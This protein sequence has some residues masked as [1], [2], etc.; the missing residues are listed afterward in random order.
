MA[1]SLNQAV[2][3]IRIGVSSCLLGE[4][5]RWDGGHKRDAF[6][7]DTLS[8]HFEL[9]PICPEVAI[10]LGSPREPIRLVMT[11]GG[12]RA[13]GVN[14]PALDV[15]AKLASY[16]REMA[17]GMSGLSGYVFKSGSP[18]CGMQRVKLHR[19]RG[20][21]PDHTAVGIYAGEIQNAFPL[22]PVEEE[23]RLGLP[24]LRDCFIECVFAYRRWCALL[25][26]GLT[27]RRLA[28]FHGRHRLALLAHA[29]E[30]TRELGRIV[31]EADRRGPANL[32]SEY[33]PLFM[34][35]LRR[36]ATRRG[37]GNAMRQ[38]LGC[39]KRMLDADGREEMRES[40]EQYRRGRLPLVVP[41]TLLRHHLRRH[42]DPN[43]AGQTY[44]EPQATELLFRT[45]S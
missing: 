44:L 12:P 11:A 10:G 23:G 34:Q 13:V 39:L 35:V 18:S 20:G 2:E 36:P 24:E 19:E 31:A 32:A 6:V 30:P 5:V 7:A 33:G 3:R 8:R 22:L 40:I 14:S 43:L 17:P 38:V 9:V 45:G 41:L 29:V 37:H 1:P 21:R 4:N 15:T 27:A 42:P 25:E 16:A 26:R 28:D